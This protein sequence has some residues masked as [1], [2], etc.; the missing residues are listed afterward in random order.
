MATFTFRFNVT[1]TE[2][3]KLVSAISQITGA[4]AKYLGMPSAAYRVDYFTIDKNGA[5]SFDDSADSVEIENLVALCAYPIMNSSLTNNIVLDSF[6]GSGSTLIACEQT[7][8]I[9]YTME[10][11]PRYVDAIIN[12]WSALT[13]LEAQL[14]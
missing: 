12:R 1:G 2:R 11:D 4:E 5:V 13:G 10:Y 9:C 7:G 8:R 14:L 6:G 3:K